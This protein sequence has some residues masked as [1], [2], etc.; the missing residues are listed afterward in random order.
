[1]VAATARV[2]PVLALGRTAR[3]ASQGVYKGGTVGYG[4]LQTRLGKWSVVFVV[5]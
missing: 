1:M 3:S 5:F 4:G 2:L